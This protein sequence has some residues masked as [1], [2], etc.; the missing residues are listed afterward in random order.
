MKSLGIIAEYNPFHKG[1]LYHLKKSMEISGADVS[2]CVM[3]GNFTQRGEKAILDKWTRSEMAIRNGVNLVLEMPFVFACN[4]AGCFASSG[5][6]ILEDL[7]VNCI[8]FGSECGNIENLK[9]IAHIIKSTEDKME[10]GIKILV[11]K[12]YS[13]PKAREIS[14][15]EFL[16]RDLLDL[17]GEPNNI[18]AIEYL[19]NIKKALPI[20]IKRYGEGYNSIESEEDIISAKHIRNK[21]MQEADI[22]NNITKAT[23][24]II[25]GNRD[26]ILNNHMFYELITYKVMMSGKDEL[27]RIYGGEEGLGDK[28]KNI[29]R[30]VTSYEEI[31]EA[32]KSKRYTHT[33]ITRYL[34]HVLVGTEKQDVLNAKNYIR[35]L[36]FDEKG[37]EF[38]NYA[39]KT[40]KTSMAVITNINKE[41][42]KYPEIKKTLDMDIKASDIYNL[43]QGLNKYEFSDMV[44]NPFRY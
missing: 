7:G 24:D 8:S 39:K 32:L 33:R 20:T 42:H 37:R 41:A 28:L 1:H 22:S 26:K 38:L 5:V 21:L 10:D 34:S 43:I 35:V 16:D 31:V 6:D 25:E 11:K 23:M 19:K 29:I 13:Y 4:N 15:K 40:E 30:T 36:G 3:S 2:V 9:K 14:L 27:N 12:G 18:L 44:K 17:I